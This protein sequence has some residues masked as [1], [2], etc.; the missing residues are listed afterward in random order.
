M[1]WSE[2]YKKEHDP[3][4]TICEGCGKVFKA[5]YAH[6]CPACFSKINSER[7]KKIGLNKLGNA[8]YSKQQAEKKGSEGK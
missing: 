1:T 8:A 2:K 3:V 4:S 7:A 6:Y 5:K